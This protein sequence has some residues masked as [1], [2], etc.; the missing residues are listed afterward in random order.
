[1]KTCVTGGAG[2]IGSHLVDRLL[3]DG[4][5]VVVFDDLST[6]RRENLAAAWGR[7]T[8]V[9]DDV[10][11]PEAVARAVEDCEVVYHQA[12]LAAVARSLERPG[13]VNEVNVL[14]T[15]NVLLGARD[16]GARR[17][18]FASSSSV[19]GDTPTLPKRETM[20]PSPRSPY[21]A[22]KAA[23]EAYYCR[24]RAYYDLKNGKAAEADLRK[25]LENLPHGYARGLASLTLADNY[26]D[27]L[28]KSP[29]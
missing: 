19:Y 1:M 6:G 9:E 21:A 8:F 25:A 2:F 29:Q 7:I 10:R 14:G 13:E 5:E 17:V 24:G 18:V 4:H 22:T 27:N 20:P 11:D 23:G 12:A 16:A 28:N 15:L 3:A 26:R